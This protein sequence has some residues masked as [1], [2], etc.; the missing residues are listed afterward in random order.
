MLNSISQL[1]LLGRLADPVSRVSTASAANA[2]VSVVRRLHSRAEA[3]R[4]FVDI[5]HFRQ[6][7]NERRSDGDARVVRCRV[8]YHR[9]S[10]L[11][12][13]VRRPTVSKERLAAYSPQEYCAVDRNGLVELKT[14]D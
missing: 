3:L 12:R 11:M 4:G 5:C 14:L 13:R 6:S 2:I 1:G 9:N 8:I 7:E 10:S